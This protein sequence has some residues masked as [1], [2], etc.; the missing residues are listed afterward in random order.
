MSNL[1]VPWP[2][3]VD[4]FEPL[5]PLDSISKKLGLTPAE[6]VGPTAVV[7]WDGLTGIKNAALI[8]R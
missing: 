3:T 1:S 6:V 7:V 4:R 2:V 5:F 8:I